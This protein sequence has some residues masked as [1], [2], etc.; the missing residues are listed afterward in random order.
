MNVYFDKLLDLKTKNNG[1][2][3]IYTITNKSNEILED[4][5]IF[6]TLFDKIKINKLLEPGKSI[7]IRKKIDII[8][9]TIDESVV[10]ANSK[11][12]NKLYFS[13]KNL[14]DISCCFLSAS[15]DYKNFIKDTYFYIF[16]GNIYKTAID[17]KI[18]LTGTNRKSLV[19][20]L[21]MLTSTSKIKIKENEIIIY[22]NKIEE[23][24]SFMIS[25]IV[26]KENGVQTR[27]TGIIK[28]SNYQLNN[29]Y[30]F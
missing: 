1:N 26:P 3:I 25:F 23:E 5:T 22:F 30:I 8:D 15:L 18:I 21:K 12:N 28:S 17:V 4:F 29:S 27:F 9:D 24:Q 7:L 11:I 10:F 2:N 20:Q 16:I 19:N 13:N 6:S 14:I